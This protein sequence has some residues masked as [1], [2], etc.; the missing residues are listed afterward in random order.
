MRVLEKQPER[1]ENLAAEIIPC[2]SKQRA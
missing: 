2:S 1:P